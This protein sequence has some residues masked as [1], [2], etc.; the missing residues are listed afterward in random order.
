MFLLFMAVLDMKQRNNKMTNSKLLKYDFYR[1][2][3]GRLCAIKDKY[4]QMYKHY[5]NEKCPIKKKIFEARLKEI[6]LCISEIEFIKNNVEDDF[7]EQ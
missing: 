1:R 3:N 7:R 6:A 5:K 4:N 2:I